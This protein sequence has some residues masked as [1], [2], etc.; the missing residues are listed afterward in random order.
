MTN[1]FRDQLASGR[2][3]MAH[4]IRVWHERNGWSHKVLPALSESLNLGK[5]HNSQ[6]SNLRNG[7]LFSPGPEVFLALAKSNEV[8]SEGIESISQQLQ[9]VHPELLKV[10]L[11]SAIPLENDY[12]QP[13]KA[14]EFF[15]IFVGLASLPESFDWF[16]EDDDEASSLCAAIADCFCQGKSW[17]ECRE[18][19]LA[20]YPVIK[21]SRRERFA[22]VMAGLNDYSANDLDG[23]LFDLYATH[24]NL[25][26]SDS[27]GMNLF[28]QDLRARAR[29]LGR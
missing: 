19:V 6:I 24:R 11:E 17:R 7:K 8:I 13:L 29:L 1:D 27:V 26:G 2:R 21:S 12:G 22:E 16:I 23:E 5:V 9:D 14:G 28:L 18:K 15:E 20:A 10:L 3:A 25:V 4:L